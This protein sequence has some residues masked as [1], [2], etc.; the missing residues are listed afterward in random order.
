MNRKKL[1]I[2]AEAKGNIAEI[3]IDGEISSWENTATTFKTQLDQLVA[4]GITDAIIYIN[5]GGGSCFQANEIANEL[6][7]FKGRKTAMLG[8]L[9][10]SAATYIAC[11]CD[12]V[13]SVRNISYMIHKPSIYVGGNSTELESTLKLL[14]NLEADYA[15]TY[16]EKTGLS[17]KEIE[18]LWVSDYWMNAEEAKSKG[19]IDEIDG[20]AII[21]A[22]DVEVVKMYKNAPNIT[23]SVT[24]HEPQT[25]NDKM[26]NL[27]ITALALVATTT[28]AEVVA[29]VEEL[30]AK[31]SKA[32]D[33]QAKLDT[34]LLAS[35]TEKATAAYEKALAGKKVI[36]SSKDFWVKQLMENYDEANATL[37]AMPAMIK[38]SE[39]TSGAITG[40]SID[41]S[42]WTYADY[43]EKDA[44]ALAE[45][46]TNDEAKFKELAKA[47]YGADFKI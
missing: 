20:E 47:H 33:L 35:K 15:R 36:A 14:K 44:T 19:F 42:S 2:T 25:I 17:I 3:R 39:Q 18:S 23:A 1:N 45:L 34:L 30:K 41:R 37:E 16:S 24:K 21:T 29:K 6:I 43:Q 40:S 26:K 32:D 10:A 27:L 12:K 28:E 4:S 31:A 7:K 38:L 9:C 8:A 13:S 46:A 5:S 11:K 22:Q